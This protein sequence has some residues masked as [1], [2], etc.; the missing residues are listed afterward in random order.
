M[1]TAQ[2]MFLRLGLQC[3]QLL[4][5]KNS[6]GIT[7]ELN[8]LRNARLEKGVGVGSNFKEHCFVH[9]KKKQFF[10]QERVHKVLHDPV[11]AE[12]SNTGKNFLH[13]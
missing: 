2:E 10:R 7:P 4:I 6:T 5:I 8:K 11:H 13:F 1:D 12:I 3:H 9:K